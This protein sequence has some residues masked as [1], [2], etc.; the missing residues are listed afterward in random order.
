MEG[1][2][3][4]LDGDL[5]RWAGRVHRIQFERPERKQDVLAVAVLVLP[6]K[7]RFD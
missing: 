7:H 6:Q 2:R 1:Q 3:G 5:V 4:R